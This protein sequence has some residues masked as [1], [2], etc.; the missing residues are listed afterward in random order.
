LRKHQILSKVSF[1]EAFLHT[2]LNENPMKDTALFVALR[3][4][5]LSLSQKS[6]NNMGFIRILTYLAVG[7]VG[8]GTA[9]LVIV[10]SVFN[11]L[12][13]LTIT[14]F[15][16]CNAELKVEPQK[17]K[18]FEFDSLRAVELSHLQGVQSLTKV[19][20]EN[21]L[22]R[23]S[24]SEPVIV[25]VKGLENNFLEQYPLD[26]ALLEGS[27]DAD[28]RALIGVG[29]QYKLGINLANEFDI[30]QLWYPRNESQLLL[31]PSRSFRKMGIAVSGV[32]ALEQNFDEKTVIVPLKFMQELMDLGPNEYTAIEIKTQGNILK[33]KEKIAAFLG[34][35]FKVLDRI[36]QQN[37]I[38]Q[39]IKIER[40]FVFVAFVFII[41][42][43]AFNIFFSLAMLS[44]Q[45]KRENGILFAMGADK[46]LLSK[47]Y[48][49][50][51]LMIGAAGVLLG[52]LLGFVLCSLQQKFGLVSLG[53]S[54]TII[55]SY[56]ISMEIRDFLNV[57][58]AVFV[59][60]F[61]SS[62]VPAQNAARQQN[63]NLK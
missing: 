35:D 61:V 5:G 48:L 15:E 12:E 56:P 7:G 36:E 63:I 55:Q 49:Y 34:K 52:L 23:Y 39:A 51:G 50:L 27:I 21:A 58:L 1:Q 59:I 29:V 54:E 20:S 19:C 53:T 6:L 44:I 10:L 11:G 40:L 46:T 62:F 24:D 42:I 14:L 33:V 47:I 22:A 13:Q 9:A 60:T 45:K 25:E 2:K 17:G 30:L 18:T 28:K 37:S 38:L 57:S 31:D 16:T 26:T 43:A 32:L 3:Y 8:V 41:S 4:F